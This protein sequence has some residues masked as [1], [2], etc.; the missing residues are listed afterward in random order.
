MF[1]SSVAFSQLNTHFVTTWNTDNSGVSGSTQIEIPT[2]PT[3]TYNYDVDWDNDG[4][5]DDF[6][7]TGNTIHNYDMAGTYTIRIRGNFPRIFFNYDPS[8][9]NSDGEKILNVEQWGSQIWTSFE[10]AFRGCT[11]YNG[12]ASDTPNL[13]NVTDMSLMFNYASSFN[14]DISGWNVES[15]IYMN[16]MFSNA[17]SFNHSI[18]DWD[19]GNATDMASMFN[20]AYSFNQNIGSWNV[21]NVTNMTSMFRS[22]VDFN[23]SL[24]NWDVGNVIDMNNMFYSAVSFNQDIGDWNVTNVTNMFYMFCNAFLFNQDIANWNVGNVENMWN[25]F[26]RAFDFNQDIGNWDVSNVLYL[27]GMFG[28]TEQFDQNIGNWNVE[29]VIDFSI[30]FIGATLSTSNYDSLLIGWNSQSLQPNMNFH[31]GYSQYCEGQ[32]ARENMI[33]LDNWVIS[34][35]GVEAGCSLSMQDAVSKNVSIYPNPSNGVF[36]V[37][38]DNIT[39]SIKKI[40]VLDISGHAIFINDDINEGTFNIDLSLIPKGVYIIEIITNNKKVLKKLILK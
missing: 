24:G 4:V 1:I 22:A 14:G 6:G 20:S 26:Y 35:S 16:G 2:H 13:S 34:D 3:T 29:N 27:H 30:M 15:V 28:F 17:Y 19:V 25:M 11:N 31:G 21:E 9:P 8:D 5:F 36:S 37:F 40:S 32:L 7:L 33:S 18:A 23:Q 39:S 38:S 12:T 10:S